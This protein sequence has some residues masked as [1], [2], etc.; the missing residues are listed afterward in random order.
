MSSNFITFDSNV[1]AFGASTV[2]HNIGFQYDTTSNQ[3]FGGAL[4]SGAMS[5][6]VFTF[7]DKFYIGSNAYSLPLVDGVS[8]NVLATDGSGTVSWVEATSGPTGQTGATGPVGAA[9]QTTGRTFY[10]DPSANSDISGVKVALTTPSAN[11]ETT[12]AVGLTGTGNTLLASFATEP[13]VPNT[14]SLPAGM[15]YR[16][17]YATTG[18]V[19]Q[20]AHLVLETYTCDADGTN[21]VL[22]RT[23]TSINFNN[24][25]QAITQTTVQ[26]T[27]VSMTSTQRLIYKLYG[28]RVSGPATCNI[29]V[30]FNGNTRV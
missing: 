8:T 12:I 11:A 22:R 18:A 2:Q 1:F 17:F 24:I 13:G 9:G 27:A 5:T 25:Q 16:Q 4:I 26:Q 30:Y 23:T 29:T 15:N 28:A 3:I 20:I 14:T 7:G 6:T 19:N 21:Q 10:L